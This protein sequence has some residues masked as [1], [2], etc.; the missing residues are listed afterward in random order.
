MG[1]R[2]GPCVQRPGAGLRSATKIQRSAAVSSARGPG[3]RR[4]QAS[5]GGA[6]ADPVRTGADVLFA[7]NQGTWPAWTSGRWF[8]GPGVRQAGESPAEDSEPNT[9]DHSGGPKLSQA[10]GYPAGGVGE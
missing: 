5:T 7:R 1:G 4:H 2:V 8:A 6:G 3:S 10:S 9:E